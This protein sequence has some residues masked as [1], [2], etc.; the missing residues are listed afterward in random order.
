MNRPCCEG[1]CLCRKPDTGYVQWANQAAERSTT[2]KHRHFFFE[3]EYYKIL[4][5]R[6]LVDTLVPVQ[7]NPVV[8]DRSAD[9]PGS[10]AGRNK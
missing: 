8:S 7:Q 9:K 5:K 3:L 2:A 6:V 10:Q 4:D 1:D